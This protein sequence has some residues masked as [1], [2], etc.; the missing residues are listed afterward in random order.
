MIL[1]EHCVWSLISETEV[2]SLYDSTDHNFDTQLLCRLLKTI[3]LFHGL[4][5]FLC[6]TSWYKR[7]KVTVESLFRFLCSLSSSV[8]SWL[9]KMLFMSARPLTI[10]CAQTDQKEGG[11][12]NYSKLFQCRNNYAQCVL[13]VDQNNMPQQLS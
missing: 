1:L 3:F 10:K 12:L 7:E 5:V 9:E 8:L 11:L 4:S 6:H 13:V 2:I